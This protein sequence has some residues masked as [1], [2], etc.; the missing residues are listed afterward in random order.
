[1]ALISTLTELK[2]DR[3]QVH[4][5]VDCGWTVFEEGG[6]RYLQLDTYGSQERKILGKT[7]QSIQ[8]DAKSAAELK[9]LIE[10]TFPGL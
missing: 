1:M 8:L 2:K 3:N 9:R 7:S 10:R 4:G 6:E 5:P